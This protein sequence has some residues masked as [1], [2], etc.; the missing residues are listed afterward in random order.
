MDTQQRLIA[1]VRSLCAADP[2]LDAALM[3]GSFAQGVADEYSDIEFWFFTDGDVD[4][5]AWLDQLGPLLS[6]VVNEF[7]SHVVFFPGLIRGEFHFAAAS[8]LGQVADWPWL[9]APVDDVI[10]LDR[11]GVLR[12]L[13][14][15]TPQRLVVPG[16]A[17]EIERL[18]LRYANWLVLGLHVRARGEIMRTHDALANVHRHLLW[19]TRLRADA[20]RTW[21]TP[22]R[23]AE[24]ELPAADVAHLHAALTGDVAAG[25]ARAWEAGRNV[26]RDLASRHGF[27]FPEALV[28]EIDAR[29]MQTLTD[30]RT[31]IA[32][33][34]SKSIDTGA[35]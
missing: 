22:S 2:R 15:R 32:S 26:W 27:E 1:L 12:E 9:G 28:A 23:R 18:C 25:L 5:R 14:G 21:L 3:Y 31:D 30:H 11:R 4:P 10:V 24:A 34:N 33:S 7:G 35:E 13:L 16:T 29:V 8:E 17:S 19:M 20:T 6:V